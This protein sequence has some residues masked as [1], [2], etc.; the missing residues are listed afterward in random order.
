M[1]AVRDVGARFIA[2]GHGMPCPYILEPCVE[3]VSK[4]NDVMAGLSCAPTVGWREMRAEVPASCPPRV[5][6]PARDSV[7]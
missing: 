4:R 3:Y 1:P 5:A 2:P 6:P 7:W